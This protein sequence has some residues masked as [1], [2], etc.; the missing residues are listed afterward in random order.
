MSDSIFE[1]SIYH[2]D[3]LVITQEIIMEDRA[4]EV[5]AR[6]DDESSRFEDMMLIIL[7]SAL[8]AVWFGACNS[9][10]EIVKESSIYKRERSINLKI[11]P[12]LLS[13]SS[14]LGLIGLAQSILYVGILGIFIGVPNFLLLILAF[15]MVIFS[16]SMMGLTIS[17]FVANTSSAT[18]MLPIVLLPQ[19]ILSGGLFPIADVE[20]EAAQM[21]FNVAVAKWGFELIGGGV[22]DV[23]SLIAF[24]EPP[25][26]AFEGPFEAHWW[27]L[28]GLTVA[29]FIIAVFSMLKKDKELT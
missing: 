23:N 19:V 27:W 1:K 29:F 3:D 4:D 15:F 17:A 16:S 5:Q 14:V 18:S 22:L 28:I 21:I 2:P 20:P 13:K 9:V 7:V 26:P 25:Y 8:C 10:G 11:A 6:I 24:K 12:Y